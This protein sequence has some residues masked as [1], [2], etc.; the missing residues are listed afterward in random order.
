MSKYFLKFARITNA[1]YDRDRRY[2]D[3]DCRKDGGIG[4]AYMLLLGVLPA[5]FDLV[6]TLLSDGFLTL[7]LHD[8]Y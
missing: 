2:L 4:R 6:F 5:H 1:F 8:S 3:E 7:K